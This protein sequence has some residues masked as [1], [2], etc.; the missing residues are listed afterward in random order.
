MPWR[1]R[2]VVRL[3]LLLVL[4]H[5]AQLTG[6]APIEAASNQRLLIMQMKANGGDVEAVLNDRKGLPPSLQ[7]ISRQ[8]LQLLLKA[9]SYGQGHTYVGSLDCTTMMSE[10]LSA[11]TRGMLLVHSPGGVGTSSFFENMWPVAE[12]AGLVMVSDF[13][14]SGKE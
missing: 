12:A 5:A 6:A 7:E 1:A 13:S 11:V 3:A 4:A 8:R 9:A 10:Q 2:R 14:S